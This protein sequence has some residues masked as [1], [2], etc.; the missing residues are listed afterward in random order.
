M[1]IYKTRPE[2][3]V[4]CFLLA[5]KLFTYK[6]NN[7]NSKAWCAAVKVTAFYFFFQQM[8]YLHLQV[9]FIAAVTVLANRCSVF[10]GNAGTTGS[11]ALIFRRNLLLMGA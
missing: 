9:C 11:S 6:K 2:P 10:Y 8:L 1:N 5:S 3:H 4:I 7:Y